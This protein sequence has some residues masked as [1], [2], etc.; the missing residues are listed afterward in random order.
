[1]KCLVF[2]DSHNYIEFMDR[3]MRLHPD[4][5][6][7]FFLGDG[8]SDFEDISYKYTA[9]KHFAVRGNCDLRAIAMGEHVKKTDSITLEGKKI[10]F[11]HGDLYG[12][13]YGNDGLIALAREQGAD[14]ILFGHT[15]MPYLKYIPVPDDVPE[16][17][18]PPLR[19]IY[20]FNPGS[21]GYCASP[22]YGVMT[23]TGGE[24]FF[25]HGSF[26]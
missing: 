14:I 17:E 10:V 2:S 24:P 12:A 21:I 26:H 23:L 16:N 3:A 5:D 15:H 9:V 19:P 6:V 13:K 20:L 11:T 25:S 22:S 4:T 8:I 1:M 18:Y 7:V